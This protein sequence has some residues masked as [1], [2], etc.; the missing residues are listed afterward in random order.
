M[1]SKKWSLNCSAM[2][3]MPPPRD[4]IQQTRHRTEAGSE[5]ED[6]GNIFAEIQEISGTVWTSWRLLGFYSDYPVSRYKV[7]RASNEGPYEGL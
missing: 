7:T 3:P 2:F 1:I 6:S 5:E 4:S